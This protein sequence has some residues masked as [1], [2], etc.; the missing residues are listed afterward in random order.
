VWLTRLRSKGNLVELASNL[1]EVYA[2]LSCCT[3]GVRAELFRL[4]PD[5]AARLTRAIREASEHVRQNPDDA[6]EVFERYTPKVPVADL[7]A[8]LRSHTHDHH[9]SGAALREEVVE[10]IA[11]LKRA[12]VI[13]PNTD[14]VKLA[15][16]IVVDVPA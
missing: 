11:D 8:M 10:I 14:P 3:L 13:R 4:E 5:T 7:A 2:D 12:N 1:S 9:P 6:A 15:Q 16:R